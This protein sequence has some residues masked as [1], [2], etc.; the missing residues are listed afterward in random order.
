MSMA[1]PP[2]LELAR[3]AEGCENIA[4]VSASTEQELLLRALDG[5]GRAFASLVAEHLPMLYRIAARACGDRALAEDAVQE[6]LSLAYERLHR[7]EA[8]TSLKSYLAAFVVRKA[9]TLL[10]SERRRRL[11]EAES[12]APTAMADPAQAASA[13]RVAERVR[14]AL[15]NMP[16]KRREVA[17]L[18]LDGALSYAEIAEAV[19]TTEG[20]AR[21]LVHLAMKELRDELKDL[22][23]AEEASNDP[24]RSD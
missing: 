11:R 15:G 24:A 18:R 8:G 5:D 10:R 1:W 12:H 23:G 16:K 14:T 22:L 4:R 7:Y 9:Q 19:G 20:S 6:A 21:V 13:A 3:G 2:A 17:L